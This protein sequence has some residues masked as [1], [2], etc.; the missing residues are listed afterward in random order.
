MTITATYQVGTY[1]DKS[2]HL[3]PEYF[4]IKF[5]DSYRF[6]NKGLEK[7]VLF[8]DSLPITKSF[9]PDEDEF[10]IL[11]RKGIFPYE[12][13]DSLEKLN[14]TSLPSK[15]AFYSEL[16]G[17]HISTKDYLFA[18]LVWRKFNC[19]TFKDYH[20]L[21]MK[22]DVLLLADVFENFREICLKNYGLDPA[23]YVSSPNL[24]WDAA[25]KLTGEKLELITDND[26]YLMWEQAKRGGVSQ[27]CTKRYAK[28]DDEA[29]EISRN[30]CLTSNRKLKFIMYYD[31]NNLYGHSMSQP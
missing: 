1:V 8:Q 13:F 23:Y 31:A 4:K 20:D 2:R 22:L 15:E 7:L 5:I 27:V 3:K 26:M 18:K 16:T 17:K 11:K 30:P 6:L 28:S 19:R 10:N 25:L 21:Y 12:W 9:F 29:L 24:A 14:C